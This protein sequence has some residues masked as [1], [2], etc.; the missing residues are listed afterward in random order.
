MCVLKWKE[1]KRTCD[2][3]YLV[4]QIACN[5]I[6]L[7]HTHIN[8]C[9]SIVWYSVRGGSER[10]AKLMHIYYLP[11]KWHID[12]A[13][14]KHITRRRFRSNFGV[15]FSNEILCVFDKFHFRIRRVAWRLFERR[16]LGRTNGTACTDCWTGCTLSGCSIGRSKTE[17]PGSGVD[18]HVARVS[19]QFG[20]KRR[21]CRRT[22]STAFDWLWWLCKSQWRFTIVGHW[23]Y[24]ISNSERPKTSTESWSSID[25]TTK[26]LFS[27]INVSCISI[28]AHIAFTG[29]RK[30]GFQIDRGILTTIHHFDR[31]TPML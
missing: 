19:I 10:A 18:I 30:R 12:N 27:T 5:A 16:F 7:T 6:R 22:K 28:S 26:R 23:Q 31:F 25:T 15:A 24:F 29:K 17:F 1:W 20:G 3:F 11:S 13:L 14:D 21:C 9:I 4:W 8:K 2:T